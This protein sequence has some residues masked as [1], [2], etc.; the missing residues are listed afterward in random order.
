MIPKGERKWRREVGADR[1]SVLNQLLLKYLTLAIPQKHEI[2]WV[3]GL[4]P[5]VVGRHQEL[6]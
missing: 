2:M 3:L 6:L 1:G 5:H 4:A